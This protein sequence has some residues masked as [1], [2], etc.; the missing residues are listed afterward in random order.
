MSVSLSVCPDFGGQISRKLKQLG[1]KLLWGA[2]RKVVGGYRMVTSTMT[3]RDPMTSYSWRHNF[4]NA[5]SP[6]VL[7]GIRPYFNKIIYCIV[8]P[9]ATRMVD[10]GLLTSVVT[11][12]RKNLKSSISQKL[13]EIRAW[14]VLI[15]YRK[16]HM[17]LRM[18]TWPMTSGSVWRHTEVAMKSWPSKCVRL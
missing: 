15:T 3:S 11:S 8:R 18:V 10:P 5:S 2:Y 7:V 4:Q 9:N 13:S 6:T 16:S 14:S 1:A 12:S 17:L